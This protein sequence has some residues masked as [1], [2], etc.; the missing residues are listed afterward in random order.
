MDNSIDN[1]QFISR[2]KEQ[3]N[4]SNEQ[5]TL[6]SDD[7]LKFEIETERIIERLYN[8]WL[9]KTKK[10]GIWEEDP[11]K[12]AMMSKELA[13][14]LVNSINLKIVPPALISQYPNEELIN[15]IAWETAKVWNR[16]VRF[17]AKKYKIQVEDLR[18]VMQND[19]PYII[20]QL[21]YLGYQGFNNR[22]R[23]ERGKIMI[24]KSETNT[25]SGGLS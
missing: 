25:N 15:D 14:K 18:V 20:K 23:V 11:N 19:I 2:P 12:K 1:R 10:D 24:T 22:M 5:V 13:D 16:H 21:L 9:G 17:E 7:V 4:K 3:Q 8:S 6:E